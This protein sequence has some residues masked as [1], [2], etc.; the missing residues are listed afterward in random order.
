MNIPLVLIDELL[1]LE[2]STH[3]DLVCD[4]FN[5]HHH[6][7]EKFIKADSLK[8]IRT[9]KHNVHTFVEVEFILDKRIYF[10]HNKD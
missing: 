9:L 5:A 1:A 3:S 10:K 6:T 8:R 7:R 4:N 2:F